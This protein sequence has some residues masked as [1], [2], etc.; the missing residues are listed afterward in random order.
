MLPDFISIFLKGSHVVISQSKLAWM[1]QKLFF[2][3]TKNSIWI[4]NIELP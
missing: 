4:K 3:I 2:I 1:F